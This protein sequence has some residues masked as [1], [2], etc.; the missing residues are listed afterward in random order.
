MCLRIC[1]L[2]T[3]PR[4]TRLREKSRAE[5]A[6]IQERHLGVC[7]ARDA[8]VKDDLSLCPTRRILQFDENCNEKESAFHTS[9]LSLATVPE[10]SD[11][12]SVLAVGETCCRH[13]IGKNLMAHSFGRAI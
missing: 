12:R 4:P 13:F 2:L 11:G 9:A 3:T 5:R 10:F 1:L 6:P 7:L 8:V